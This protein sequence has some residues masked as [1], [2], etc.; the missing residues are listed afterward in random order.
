MGSVNGIQREKIRPRHAINFSMPCAC[1]G[2]K[3]FCAGNALW[4]AQWHADY[5][6]TTGWPQIIFRFVAHSS[7]DCRFFCGK[8]KGFFFAKKYNTLWNNEISTFLCVLMSHHRNAASLGIPPS[9]LGV[10][11]SLLCIFVFLCFCEKENI[12]CLTLYKNNEYIY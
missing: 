6:D 10:L 4:M 12:T 1:R 11:H 8:S 9:Q 3:K 2:V 7:K 5:T